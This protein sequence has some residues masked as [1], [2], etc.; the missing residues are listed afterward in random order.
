MISQLNVKLTVWSTK[1]PKTNSI[2]NINQPKNTQQVRF[3]QIIQTEKKVVV[4]FLKQEALVLNRSVNLGLVQQV[5]QQV[6]FPVKAIENYEIEI[7]K[8]KESKIGVVACSDPVNVPNF[9]Q[10]LS[11]VCNFIKENACKLQ[12]NCKVELLL[13][14]GGCQKFKVNFEQLQ[15]NLMITVFHNLDAVQV[16]E[17]SQQIKTSL[18]FNKISASLFF[19]TV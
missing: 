17:L 13:D 8:N 15:S 14:V 3:S 2:K 11:F 6:S 10:A 5:K 19:I 1:I 9:E 4:D 12:S 18:R 7:E 16:Q